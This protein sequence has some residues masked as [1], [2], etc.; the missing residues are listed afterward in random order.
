MKPLKVR[1]KVLVKCPVS[2]LVIDSHVVNDE[3]SLTDQSFKDQCD[4][5]VIM[6]RFEQ[7]GQIQH[8]NQRQAHYGD[9][10]DKPDF[11]GAM[12][13]IAEAKQDFMSLDAHIRAKFHHKMENYVAFLQ[14]P[15]NDDEAVKLGLK[16]RPELPLPQEVVIKEDKRPTPPK[17]KSSEPSKPE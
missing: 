2:G 13:L 5:N 1:Q 12:C 7:T 3:P 15:A 16:T 17:K 10:S 11:F 9:W 6:K 14:D 4:S 8:L